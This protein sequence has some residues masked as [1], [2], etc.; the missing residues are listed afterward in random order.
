MA[1]GEE[2]SGGRLL[3][4]MPPRPRDEDLLRCYREFLAIVTWARHLLEHQA[5]ELQVAAAA[6]HHRTLPS[7]ATPPHLGHTPPAAAAHHRHTKRHQYH[8]ITTAPP[9]DHQQTTT[10]PGSRAARG[11][12]G[13]RRR[14]REGARRG[15][16]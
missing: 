5:A 1:A 4:V 10:P 6:H 3:H 13:A 8:H 14:S 9:Q 2:S 7:P 11:T 15:S 16:L 12:R